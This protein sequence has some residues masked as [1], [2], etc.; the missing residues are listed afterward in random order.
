MVCYAMAFIIRFKFNAADDKR[1]CCSAAS[2][3]L[4][5][6]NFKLSPVF[7]AARLPSLHI[8][9][10]SKTFV[11]L[12]GPSFSCFFLTTS[13]DIFTWILLSVPFSPMHLLWKGQSLHT[14]F[15]HRYSFVTVFI[16]L[17]SLCIGSSFFPGQ[18]KAS[19]PSSY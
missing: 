8:C 7:W 14:V 9:R 12:S 2:N 11:C 17:L 18:I 1:H 6:K 5:Y 3:P 4:L 19:F 16:V 15:G 10:S 13:S